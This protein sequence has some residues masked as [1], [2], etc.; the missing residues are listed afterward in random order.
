MPGTVHGAHVF[1]ASDATVGA[2]PQPVGVDDD[3]DSLPP[4]VGSVPPSYI[5]S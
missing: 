5:V 1:H 2:H 3:S 4:Y